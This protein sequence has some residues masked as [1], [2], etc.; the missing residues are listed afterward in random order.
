[1]FCQEPLKSHD[2]ANFYSAS[3]ALISFVHN[4]CSTVNGVFSPMPQSDTFPPYI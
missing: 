3:K 4:G 1:M 2:T